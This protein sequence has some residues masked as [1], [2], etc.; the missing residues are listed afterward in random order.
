[1]EQKQTN[2]WPKTQFLI[3]QQQQTPLNKMRI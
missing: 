1:M 3:M 2:I